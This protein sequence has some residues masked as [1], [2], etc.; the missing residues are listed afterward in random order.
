MSEVLTDVAKTAVR[1]V[2]KSN[3]QQ[4]KATDAEREILASASPPVLAPIAQDYA[5]WR[6]SL[7]YLGALALAAWSILGLAGFQDFA[8]V[9]RDRIKRADLS[10]E[11][12]TQALAQTESVLKLLGTENTEMIDAVRMVLLLTIC[13]G[14]IFLFLGAKTW[15]NLRVSRRWARLAFYIIFLT[16]FILAAIPFTALMDFSHLPEAQVKPARTMLGMELGGILFL[17]VGPRALALFPAIIRSSITLKTLIP[18]SPLAGWAATILG[19][20][21]PVLLIVLVSTINQVSGDFLLLGGVACLTIAPLIYI[22]NAKE[23]MRSH[24]EDEVA[25]TVVAIRRKVLLFNGGGMILLGMFVLNFD[26]FGAMDATRFLASF[27]GNFLLVTLVAS[28]LLL[29]LMRAGHQQGK[30]FNGTELAD[31]LDT[32]FDSLGGVGLTDIRTPKE[33]K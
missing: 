31:A 12:R 27:L 15:S 19:L 6:R 24:R 33:A 10:D 30:Q 29:A 14:A 22:R 28:D 25:D 5:A 18:E 21:Y 8:D 2:A 17:V 32:K 20:F 11:Q 4:E 3:F 23:I 13:V 7:L 1:R 9:S 26:L 16:P